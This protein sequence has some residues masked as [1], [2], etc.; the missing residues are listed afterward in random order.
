M[1]S[2]Q[3][4]M[5]QMRQRALS[6][7]LTTLSITLGV[8]LVIAILILY[9]E[10]NSL[11][12]QSDFGYDVLVG[13]KGSPLQLTLNTV[14]HVDKSPGN[15]PYKMYDELA[16]K[17]TYRRYVRNA[18]P[19]CVGDSYKGLRIVGTTPKMFAYTD[20]GDRVTDHPFEYRPG[21]SYE[22][23]DGAMFNPNKFE[24]VIGSDVTKLTGLKLGDIFQATHGMP[25]PNVVP[26][27]HEEKW[28]VVGVLKQTHTSADRVLYIPLLSFYTIAE[29]G[30]GLIKQ[31]E[32]RDGGPPSTQL[33]KEEEEP[34]H[35]T[36]N[37][38]GT[39]NLQLSTSCRIFSP[40]FLHPARWFCWSSPGS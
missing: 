38:D 2:L 12:G 24:A 18:V 40:R 37:P 14:Y 7:W 25:D 29:H 30:V 28:K 31:A 33:A 1:N 17:A 4:T 15:I 36:M 16:H 34:K 6:T 9:R 26:D 21:R 10:G 32:I 19:I 8:A 5:K 39:I 20:E 22:V 11:F 3:L 13:I 35:Y 27:I 23:A